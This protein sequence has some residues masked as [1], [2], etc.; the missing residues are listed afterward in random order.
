MKVTLLSLTEAVQKA[1]AAFVGAKTD[2]ERATAGRALADALDAKVKYSKR[3]RTDELEEDD[4]DESADSSG[5]PST[6]PS[7]DAPSSSGKSSASA[8]AE[9]ASGSADA[10]SADAEAEGD[11]SKKMKSRAV[12]A[13]RSRRACADAV[14]DALFELTGKADLNEAVGALAGIKAVLTSHS[15]LAADVA[16]LKSAARASKVEDM[17]ARAQR[18][19][20][21]GKSAKTVEKLRAQGL[22]DPKFLK[23]YLASLPKQ[24][25]TTEDV[26]VSPR[27]SQGSAIVSFASLDKESREMI[28]VGARAAGMEI[29]KYFELFK[30]TS[31]K[32]GGNTGAGTH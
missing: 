26:V 3:T 16:S 8:D 29:D 25:R 23:G 24:V 19:G 21:L 7:S 10:E 22:K 11:D 14:Y 32:M 1:Q 30:S 18:E 13:M 31:A 12:R 9:S 5:P 20:R 2:E 28:E 6:K 4:G 27:E 17:I 15:K